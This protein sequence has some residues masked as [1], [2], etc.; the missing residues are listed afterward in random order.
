MFEFVVQGQGAG[1]T[2]H[3]CW[4]YAKALDGGMGS[5]PEARVIGEAKIIVATEI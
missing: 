4:S 2:A 3:G 5:F 1:N